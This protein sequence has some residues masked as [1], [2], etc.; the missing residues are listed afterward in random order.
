MDQV[1]LASLVSECQNT[2]NKCLASPG[3]SKGQFGH[4][5]GDQRGLFNIWAANANVFARSRASLEYRLREAPYVEM[6]A[7]EILTNI[8]QTLMEI[9]TVHARRTHS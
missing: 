5:L 7:R 1:D 6:L 4:L 8:Y 2:L 3:V 9:C